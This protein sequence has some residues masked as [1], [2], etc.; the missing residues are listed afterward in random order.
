MSVTSISY[1]GL[2]VWISER[3]EQ[4]APTMSEWNQE[5]TFE[6]SWSRV[7]YILTVTSS[8]AIDR[9]CWNLILILLECTDLTLTSQQPNHDQ[10]SGCQWIIKTFLAIM[11]VEPWRR[12]ASK[13]PCLSLLI[14]EARGHSTFHFHPH[15]FKLAVS[16][17]LS[18]LAEKRA[19]LASALRADKA[20]HTRGLVL[21]RL[22][23]P[24]PWTR[25]EKSHSWDSSVPIHLLDK[26]S[27]SLGVGKM[28]AFKCTNN[29][30]LLC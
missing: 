11:F 10:C 18:L 23:S 4:H 5:D 2:R 1:D 27:E 15:S 3:L 22:I 28:A 26:D 14:I 24:S 16:F 13:L 25:P 6:Y 9:F 7:L 12:V 30:E 19:S 29:Y 17:T 21:S 8:S 20:R